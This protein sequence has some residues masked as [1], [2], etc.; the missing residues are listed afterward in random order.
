MKTSY[1]S[2]D[3]IRSFYFTESSESR[4][5][6]FKINKSKTTEILTQLSQFI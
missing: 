3:C 4:E 6:P 1:A 2:N 5:Q